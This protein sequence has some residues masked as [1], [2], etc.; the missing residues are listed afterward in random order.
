MQPI[1][2]LSQILRG[3][4]FFIEFRQ[5]DP[6]S[7]ERIF[8]LLMKFGLRRALALVSCPI[9]L[10]MTAKTR[11]FRLGFWVSDFGFGFVCGQNVTCLKRSPGAME[12]VIMGRPP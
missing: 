8:V 12:D 7:T 6:L 5:R 11:I 3:K 4:Q 9:H 2:Q 10:F 1:G